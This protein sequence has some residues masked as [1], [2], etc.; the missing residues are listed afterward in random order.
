MFENPRGYITVVARQAGHDSWKSY[1]QRDKRGAQTHPLPVR[2]AN[3][4]K[5]KGCRSNDIRPQAIGSM[6]NRHFLCA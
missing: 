4:R 6:W 5:T 1:L 2:D 3:W